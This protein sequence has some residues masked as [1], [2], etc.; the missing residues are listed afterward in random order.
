M[1]V[2]FQITRKKDF[3]AVTLGIC[4]TIKEKGADVILWERNYSV[5]GIRQHPV[6]VVA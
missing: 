2:E 5:C 6:V 1:V 3:E 4:C